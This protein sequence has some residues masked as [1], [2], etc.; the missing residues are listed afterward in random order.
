[1]RGLRS[2]ILTS[3]ALAVALAAGV[4]AAAH[5]TTGMPVLVGVRATHQRNV[6]RIIF[7]L[8]GGLPDAVVVDW[9]DQ[10]TQ[11]GSGRRVAVQGNAFLQVSLQGVLGH[12]LSEPLR[13]TYGP[14][15]R[16]FDLPNVTHVV[17]AGDFEAVVTFGIGLMRRTSVVRTTQKRDPARVIVDVAAAFKTVPVAVA[18]VETAPATPAART[19][20]V[21]PRPSDALAL[22]PRTVPATDAVNGALLRL[23]AGPTANEQAAG[24]RF[25][26][27]GSKG[28]RDLRVSAS[29]VARL[30]LTGRCA[31]GGKA[32]TVA[33]EIFATLRPLPEVEWVKIHDPAGQTR[34]PAGRSDSIPDCLAPTS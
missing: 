9:V 4:P 8:Q 12:E 26:R 31:G 34:Q 3:V 6:D 23:W 1:M 29:G 33:D 28:F 19:A 2:A 10:V 21:A 25:E 16:A 32:I 27:S 20:R 22:A 30:T 14:R 5:A 24:L 11:D 18:F 13:P 15:S 7:E 17:N